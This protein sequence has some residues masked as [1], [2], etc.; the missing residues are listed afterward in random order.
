MNQRQL[1]AEHRRL[2]EK[3]PFT[4]RE[5]KTF[6]KKDQSMIRNIQILNKISK[7]D[8]VSVIK[9]YK[10]TPKATLRRL[11][12]AYRGRLKKYSSPQKPDIRGHMKAPRNLTKRE[13]EVHA[14]NRGELRRNIASENVSSRVEAGHKKYPDA[15]IQELRHGVNSKWSSAYREK[16][17]L[18]PAYT[19]RVVK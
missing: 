19:G 5:Q 18:S 16:Q 2:N 11:A 14:V 3:E 17:G 8:A 10:S 15:S 1:K 12:K 13:K 6:D 9:A 4:K 7:K